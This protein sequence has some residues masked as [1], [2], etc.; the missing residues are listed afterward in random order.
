MGHLYKYGRSAD[1][2]PAIMSTSLLKYVTEQQRRQN[3]SDISA[4]DTC[5]TRLVTLN[6]INVQDLV[7]NDKFDKQGRLPVVEFL[8]LG[9]LKGLVTRHRGK[10]IVSGGLSAFC[11]GKTSSYADIDFWMH[12]SKWAYLMQRDCVDAL[13]MAILK[14]ARDAVIVHAGPHADTLSSSIT[15]EVNT[16]YYG[17]NTKV[18][19]VMYR[20]IHCLV[21]VCIFAPPP[22]PCTS[23]RRS[24]YNPKPVSVKHNTHPFE[25]MISQMFSEDVGH[26]SMVGGNVFRHSLINLL[27]ATVFEFDFDICKNM[28]IPLS[29]SQLLTT[30]VSG[31]TLRRQKEQIMNTPTILNTPGGFERALKY[32][33]R[34]IITENILPSDNYVYLTEVNN[35]FLLNKT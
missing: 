7:P 20:S 23:R 9:I 24:P 5:N 17:N 8:R 22:P 2:A 3:I 10:F 34:M 33:R 27:R 11:L 26:T 1:I 32:M 16:S 30:D 29:D 35:V 6:D 19:K 31:C 21:D 28:S 18:F 13:G 15:V 4:V 14:E 12:A 25:Y